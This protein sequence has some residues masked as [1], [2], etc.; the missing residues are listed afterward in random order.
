[1]PDP[2]STQTTLAETLET[3]ATQAL[4]LAIEAVERGDVWMARRHAFTAGHQLDAAAK[5]RDRA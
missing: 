4:R 1:M 5:E 3:E 2:V